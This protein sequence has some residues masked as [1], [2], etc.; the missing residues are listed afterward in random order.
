[1]FLYPLIG[2]CYRYHTCLSD[3]V[4]ACCLAGA[5]LASRLFAIYI[6]KHTST[7][8]FIKPWCGL[9]RIIKYSGMFLYR[10]SSSYLELTVSTRILFLDAKTSKLPTQRF[11]QKPALFYTVRDMHS[12]TQ[13]LLQDWCSM[14]V[15][16]SLPM[17]CSILSTS[18]QSLV[19][20]FLC[21]QVCLMHTS[22]SAYLLNSSCSTTECGNTFAAKTLS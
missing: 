7:P 13:L 3:I 6:V 2:C 8:H 1:M 5:L 17:G 22:T 18:R 16:L 14:L 4:R 21:N 11:L 15:V 10:L 20:H 19:C 12:Y 9:S